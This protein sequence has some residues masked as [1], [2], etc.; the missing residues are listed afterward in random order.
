MRA[1]PPT[2][3]FAGL[4]SLSSPLSAWNDGFSNCGWKQPRKL[5]HPDPDCR[6]YL[7]RDSWMRRKARFAGVSSAFAWASSYTENQ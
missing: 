5:F 1:S 6:G 4:L 7:G 3:F 2:G